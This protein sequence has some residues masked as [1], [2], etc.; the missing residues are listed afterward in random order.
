MRKLFAVAAAVTFLGALASPLLAADTVL[1]GELVDSACYMKDKKNVG[2][3]H[4]ECAMTCAKKGTPVALVTADGSIYM[5]TG[6]LAKDNNAQLAGHMSH[7]VELTGEVTEQDGK[8]LIAA[9]SL[10]MVS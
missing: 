3:N 6:D 8:K 7:T 1:K 2:A 4:R 10:K 9:K 5:V